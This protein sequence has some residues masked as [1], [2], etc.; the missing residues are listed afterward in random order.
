VLNEWIPY[1]K[2]IKGDFMKM[3]NIL[4]LCLIFALVL[5]S[6]TLAA[7]SSTPKLTIH[8]S[9]TSGKAPLTV[10]ISYTLTGAKEKSHTWYLGDGFSC[11]CT[12]RTYTYKHPGTYTITLKLTTTTGKTLT[13]TQKVTV[14]K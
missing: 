8:E 11:H 12:S 13:A 1:L 2:L 7:S 10:K 9:P 4:A 3:K 14:K 6:T 5:P